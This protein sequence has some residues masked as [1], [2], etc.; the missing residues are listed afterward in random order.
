MLRTGHS[1]AS[2]AD[3]RLS[4]LIPTKDRSVFLDKLLRFYASRSLGCPVY[5]GDASEQSDEA[6]KNRQAVERYRGSLKLNY[7][8]QTPGITTVAGVHQLLE[9]IST[10]YTAL[11]GDDDY[12]IPEQLRRCVEFLQTHPDY[13]CVT[14]DQAE[15]FVGLEEGNS[16]M[17]VLKIIP[18]AHKEA[19]H[20]AAS[21]RL[22]QWA[23]PAIGKNTFSVQPTAAMR[24]AWKETDALGLDLKL[25]APLHE[26]SVN[27]LTVL[28][29][30]QKHL[31]G[32]YHVMLRHTQK[33]GFSG[34]ID[35]FDRIARWD[36]PAK[37]TPALD[38][39]A[40]EIL[41]RQEGLEPEAAR[42]VAQTVFLQWL[43]PFLA[44]NRDRKLKE[45]N[46]ASIPAP[47]RQRLPGWVPLKAWI[48]SLQHHRNFEPVHAILKS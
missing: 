37:V 43:I 10:P 2:S 33:T 21:Q 39:W 45:F 24:W 20:P 5:I 40:Q 25:Y 27:V 26:L 28:Q 36:W 44:R 12:L 19:S 14:G 1:T 11:C 15:V 4:L 34:P 42:R 9:K 30:K 29:G 16:R 6:E 7:E 46:L 17:K 8:R 18:G 35:Y 23:Y 32:L 13:A 31:K 47:L 38:R 22:L 41:R 3:S 48:R